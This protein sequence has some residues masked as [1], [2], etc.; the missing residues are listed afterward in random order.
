MLVVA[1]VAAVPAVPHQAVLDGRRLEQ[2]LEHAARA[3]VLQALVRRQRVLGA[4]PPVAELAH[5]Q[6]VRLLVLVLEVPLQ[7]VVA[8]EG[9]PAVGALLRLVDAPARGRWHA[10]RQ[11]RSARLRHAP[12]GRRRRGRRLAA[13]TASVVVVVIVVVAAIGGGIGGAIVAAGAAAIA[14]GGRGAEVA[15]HTAA[16]AAG[17]RRRPAQDMTMSVEVAMAVQAVDGGGQAAVERAG[18][19]GEGRGRRGR[20]RGGAGGRGG[21]GAADAVRSCEVRG[22][23][24][25]VLIRLDRMFF[26]IRD[27][28][29]A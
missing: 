3:A 7:R 12:G 9:A 11:L 15:A 8:R 25:E 1:P 2:P 16:H 14:V 21:C 4:V 29:V 24:R 23:K 5:V 10:Q 13:R 27:I 20:R 18:G 17:T 28:G 19:R 6:R 22:E 26:R